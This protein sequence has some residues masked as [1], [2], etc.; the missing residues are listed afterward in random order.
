MK[1]IIVFSLIALFVANVFELNQIVKLPALLHHY[2]EHKSENKYESFAAFLTDHYFEQ[3]DHASQ[4]HR[5]DDLPYKSSNC[6]SFHAVIVF[7]QNENHN[8][9]HFSIFST[10]LNKK[11]QPDFYLENFE[12]KIWQPP[13]A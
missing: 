5:H 12:G 8:T 7:F 2:Y 10:S 6:S 4:H 3:H 1:K 11:P 13:K 9:Y